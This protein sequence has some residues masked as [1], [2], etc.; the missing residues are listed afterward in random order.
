MERLGSSPVTTP[1]TTPR[2]AA[3]T[4]GNFDLIVGVF[5]SLLL[6]SNVCAT[7]LI[8]IGSMDATPVMVGP[9]QLWPLI[10]DGGALLFPFTYIFGDVLAE[11]FGMARARRAI[12]LGFGVSVLASLTFLLI[13]AAPALDPELNGAFTKVL[14]FVPRIVIASLAG[15]LLGQLVN[16][17]VLVA[18]KART[19]E[20]TLWARLL[21]STVVGELV[22]TVTFCMIAFFGL[23]STGEMVNYIV[24]G[25]LWKVG[26]EAVFLPVTYQV[27]KL[28]KK[29]EPDYYDAASTTAGTRV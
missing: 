23:I 6:I 29:A 12:L 15:Y 18:M 10:T 7:K 19:K 24:V 26:V 21:G 3:G 22:D 27:I 2:Y 20:G 4:R 13:G 5:C 16:A 1:E 17:R 28:V 8:P 11:V 9:V 14:G 25:Y